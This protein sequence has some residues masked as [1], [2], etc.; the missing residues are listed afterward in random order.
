MEL[1]RNGVNSLKKSDYDPKPSSW[2]S[3]Q[4]RKYSKRE[5]RISVSLS[6]VFTIDSRFHENA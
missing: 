6:C 4:P 5:I 1:H 3:Y 2:E